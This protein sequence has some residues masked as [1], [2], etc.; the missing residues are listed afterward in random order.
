MAVRD[1]FVALSKQIIT[2]SQGT[3]K[4]GNIQMVLCFLPEKNARQYPL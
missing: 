2:A 1:A 4:P 3:I